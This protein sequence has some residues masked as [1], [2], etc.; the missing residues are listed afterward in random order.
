VPLRKSIIDV[1]ERRVAT[2]FPPTL[3]ARPGSQANAA[4]EGHSHFSHSTA[5]GNPLNLLPTQSPSLPHEHTHALTSAYTPSTRTG[6]M[7]HFRLT[8]EE[9]M[10]LA[11][12]IANALEVR[13]QDSPEVP[14]PY[15][16]DRQVAEGMGLRRGR[17]QRGRP[18][19]PVA[20]HYAMPPA[21]PRHANR[22]AQASRRPLSPA[23]QGY[24]NNQGTSYV[25]FTILD[26]T[27]STS[28]GQVHQG[29]HDRQP[30][31]RGAHDDGWTRTSG[32][33]PCSCR[34]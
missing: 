16:E 20:V 1:Q 21:H 22:G 29:P 3:R 15:P 27:G 28:S 7:A 12:N 30:I 11:D 8:R 25:P 14:P 18:R 9:A 5:A 23:A 31:C 13:R 33:N 19:Q 2:C 10:S 26:A 34:P 4:L 32:G 24:E 17:G 6:A